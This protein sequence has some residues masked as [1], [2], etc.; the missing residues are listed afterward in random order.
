MAGKALRSSA[1]RDGP[2]FAQPGSERCSEAQLGMHPGPPIKQYA[3]TPQRQAQRSGMHH[4]FQAVTP[5]LTT[6]PSKR[7]EWWL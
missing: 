1:V 6:A 2:G 5:R 4:T 7:L 3:G